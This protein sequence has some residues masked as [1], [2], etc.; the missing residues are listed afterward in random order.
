MKLPS[1]IRRTYF[2]RKLFRGCFCKTNCLNGSNNWE[3]RFNLS[4]FRPGAQ[5][6]I[7]TS[8]WEM[9]RKV[10]IV[11]NFAKFTGNTNVGVSFQW[12]CRLPGHHNNLQTIVLWRVVNTHCFGARSQMSSP[13]STNKTRWTITLVK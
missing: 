12:S 4:L 11:K 13:H 9:F 8:C 7:R 3:V 2:W 10:C 1:I 5:C 6:E